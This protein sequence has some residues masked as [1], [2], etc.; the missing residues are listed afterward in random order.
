[1]TAPLHFQLAG[2]HACYRP[3]GQVLLS[4]AIDL[5]STAIAYARESAIEKILVDSTQLTGF[6]PLNTS[7][8]FWMAKQFVT[9][10]KSVVKVALLAR[11]EM[12]DPDRFGVTVARN[13]GLH[14][15]VFDSE[16]D[17]LAWLLAD[18]SE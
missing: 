16:A 17:A 15:N 2:T 1:M 6:A 3:E 14:A 5:I 12:I 8:R 11:P 18:Q 10:A 4:E 7:A 9:A 13:L